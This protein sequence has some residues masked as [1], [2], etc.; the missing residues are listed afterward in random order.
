MEQLVVGCEPHTYH[1]TPD[2]KPTSP[3]SSGDID[4][5]TTTVQQSFINAESQNVSI[6]IAND[7]LLELDEDF[8]AN[9]VAVPTGLDVSISPSRAMV[10]ILDED[11]K[12]VIRQT[13][14]HLHVLTLALVVVHL[15]CIDTFSLYHVTGATL[16]FNPSAY[17][18]SEDGVSVT[19][20]V[21]LISGQLGRAVELNLNTRDGTAEGKN[22]SRTFRK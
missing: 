9:L 20:R 7:A 5:T 16:G 1:R 4:Y 13:L 14:P 12:S 17:N 8:F 10:T 6:A 11:S 3:P 18:V 22:R 2:M 19:L 15:P 21:Q